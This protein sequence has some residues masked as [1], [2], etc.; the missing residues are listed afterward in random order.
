MRKVLV[1][2]GPPGSGKG[3]QARKLAAY[4]KVPHVSTGDMLRDAVARGTALGRKAKEIMDAGQLVS[5]DIVDGIVAERLSQGDAEDGYILDGYPRT[6][7]Q[8]QFLERLV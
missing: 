6:I 4:L 8:A 5:D 1:L 7:R 3:T 2:L